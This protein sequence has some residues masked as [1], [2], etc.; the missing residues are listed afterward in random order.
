MAHDHSATVR[1]T[2]VE[3]TR[4]GW[5]LAVNTIAA[6]AWVGKL[7]REYSTSAGHVVELA[8]ARRITAG[9]GTDTLDLVGWIPRVVTAD[10]VGRRIAQYAE[11][12]AKTQGYKR[13]SPGQR[14]RVRVLQ[15][16]G[17]F[18]GISMMVDDR[19][20]IAEVGAIPDEIKHTR[21]GQA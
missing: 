16:A 7:R 5:R 4:R 6:V 17:A 14:N 11:I 10:M 9:L 13:M 8:G 15:E 18:V 20:T 21:E 3:A 2:L 1:L 19:L 12:D